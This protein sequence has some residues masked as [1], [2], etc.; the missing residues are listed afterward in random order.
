MK[1]YL[2]IIL[3]P[4]LVITAFSF[5]FFR[6]N[7]Q[8]VKEELACCQ[9]ELASVLEGLEDCQEANLPAH[10]ETID[11]LKKW[12]EED[13]TDQIPYDLEEFRCTDFAY[14]LQMEALKDNYILSM[15]IKDA[16]AFN[17]AYISSSK[18]Y[19]YIEPQDDRVY[20]NSSKE[21]EVR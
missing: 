7:C 17:M 1:R 5:P 3:I 18:Q 15:Y 6:D 21:N 19:L 2:G 10:F 14:T 12:L 8:E 16:H 4:I 11:E 20:Y 9:S 13:E